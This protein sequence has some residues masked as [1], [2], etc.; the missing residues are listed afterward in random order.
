MACTLYVMM[1]CN[2]LQAAISRRTTSSGILC[3]MMTKKSC[4][5]RLCWKY[6]ACNTNL[7]I[8]AHS[9]KIHK[10]NKTKSRFIKIRKKGMLKLT[11][12]TPVAFALQFCIFNFYPRP[13]LALWGLSSPASV[14]V[15]VCL[16]VGL[17]AN[18]LLVRA[19]TRDPFKLGSPNLDQRCKRPWLKTLSFRG[20]IDLDIQG[21][22]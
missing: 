5:V 19:I 17:C 9:D 7:T 21:Q 12:F 10:N 6:L 8:C 18:H 16:S 13:V 1:R 22:I 20:A 11:V 14:C 4:N 15:C 2:N 3:A